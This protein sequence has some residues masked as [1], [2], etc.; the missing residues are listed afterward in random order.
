MK[1][2]VV[3]AMFLASF[4]HAAWN[5]YTEV[6]DLELDA[7]DVEQ[8]DIDAGAGSMSVKGV[9]GLNKIL[10]KATIEVPDADEDEAIK[11][12]DK[13]MRLTLDKRGARAQLQAFFEQGFFGG[14]KGA[15]ID[16]EVS[17]P[18]GMAVHIDDGSGSIEVADVASDVT[19]DDGS[20]SIDVRGAASL[21]IDDGSGSIDVKMI[22]GDVSITDGSGGIKVHE[23][24]G[25]V[26][27]DDGSG[28]ISVS[29]VEQDL[30]IVED[31][32]GGVSISNV[33]GTVE[34]DS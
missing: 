19:I 21:F 28:S 8:I 14:S 29:D 26:T 15:G 13:K 7:A 23:V 17:V 12:I 3:M 27:I 25:S 4:A 16:L 30:I 24:A 9:D 5:N 33:G 1:G 20:G 34:Q 10:V 31:G 32:S 18:L 11:F 6:R 22:G 2:F